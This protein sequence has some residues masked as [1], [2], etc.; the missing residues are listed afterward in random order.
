MSPSI[1]ARS[2]SRRR[3]RIS[4]CSAEAAAAGPGLATDVADPLTAARQVLSIEGR[5]PSSAATCVEGATARAQQRHRLPL[6][7]I[8]ERTS[9]RRHQCTSLLRS[10]HEVSSIPG[11]GTRN[12]PRFPIAEQL[13]RYQFPLSLYPAGSGTPASASAAPVAGALAR[14]HVGVVPRQYLGER[15]E[16]RLFR[17][18]VGSDLD[19]CPIVEAGATS[20]L[21]A[22]AQALPSVTDLRGLD[23]WLCNPTVKQPSQPRSLPSQ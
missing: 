2:S 4:A 22:V 7:L 9:C 16:P 15:V 8:R 18:E 14:L 12:S 11:K 19:C 5:M 6:E 23:W 13:E 17:A 10:L 3:R 20:A 21:D 1:W